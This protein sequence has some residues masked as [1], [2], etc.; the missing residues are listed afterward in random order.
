MSFDWSWFKNTGLTSAQ[1]AAHA[2]LGVV[3]G[4]AVDLWHFDYKQAL[5]LSAGAA[6]VS[7]LGAVVAYKVPSNSG[8]SPAQQLSAHAPVV[9]PESVTE[10]GCAPGK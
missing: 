8:Q 7:L 1:S 4:N 10:V 6:V 2:L 5:G 9:N 3:G